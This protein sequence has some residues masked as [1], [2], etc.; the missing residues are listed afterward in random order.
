[1]E[2]RFGKTFRT[3]GSWNPDHPEPK[4]ERFRTEKALSRLPDASAVGAQA[5]YLKRSLLPTASAAETTA[6]PGSFLQYCRGGDK[7]IC[8]T[9]R[10]CVKYQ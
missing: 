10:Q 5:A 3:F 2:Q 9:Q 7:Q 8:T 4:Q 1:M 6:D